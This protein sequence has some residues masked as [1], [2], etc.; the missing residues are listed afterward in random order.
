MPHFLNDTQRWTTF[1][2]DEVGRLISET[3]EGLTTTFCYSSRPLGRQLL[4]MTTI[5]DP[6]GRVSNRF[7][8]LVGDLIISEDAMEGSVTYGYYAPGFVRWITAP[9]NAITEIV[10][11]KFGRQEALIE[12]NAGRIEF[13]YDAFDRIV[14]QTD[15]RGNITENEF[16]NLGRLRRTVIT[17]ATTGERRV[18]THTYITGLNNPNVGRLQSITVNDGVNNAAHIFEYD[19]FGRITK[20]KDVIG[21]DTLITRYTYCDAYGRLLTYTFPSG[22]TLHYTYDANGFKIEIRENNSTGKLIWQLDSVNAMGQE[23]SSRVGTETHNRIRTQAYNVFGQPTAMIVGELRDYTFRPHQPPPGSGLPQPPHWMAVSPTL[24]DFTY[25]YDSLT[26]NMLSRHNR[27]N[28]TNEE[29]Q[30]DALNRL[31][32]G[33]TFSLCGNITWKEG[34]GYFSYNS[35]RPHAV[36]YIL[37]M[38]RQL[39]N[40]DITYTGFQKIETIED[41]ANGLFASFIYG[42]NRQRRQ[43]TVWFDNNMLTKH[44]TQNF[45]VSYI[46]GVRKETKEYIFSPFGLVAIRNNNVVNAVATDHLGSI[47]AEFNPRRN[48]FEFFGFTAWGRRYRYE[49]GTKFFFDEKVISCQLSVV[50]FFQRGFTGHEHM[51]AF[52]LINMNG[53]LYDPLIGRF[54]SPDPFVPDATF[55]QDFNRY[56]YAR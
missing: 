15:A 41:T 5:T 12:P 26:G 16:D 39:S 31:T 7:Y 24:M 28:G 20:F 38:S 34:V 53:R 49:N 6:R 18:T 21:T 3:F 10:Y 27:F 55:T 14:R 11:D 25:T 56:M 9:G 8:N 13:V 23:L 1:E 45:E 33:I 43:M 52:G 35:N 30:Y 50:S 48:A 42:P 44:Y 47:V 29:F 17:N 36:D 51:D 19:R 46:D 37:G 22:F 32:T 2:F 4:S 40:H 54:L